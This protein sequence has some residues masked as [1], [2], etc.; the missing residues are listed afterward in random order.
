MGY[1]LLYFCMNY[2]YYL[3]YLFQANLEGSNNDTNPIEKA[4]FKVFSEEFRP[5]DDDQANVDGMTCIIIC[6]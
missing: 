2:L 3:N 4:E 6:S 1:V 5:A